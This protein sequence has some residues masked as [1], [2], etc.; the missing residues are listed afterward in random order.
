[1]HLKTITFPQKFA[2]RFNIAPTQ[3]VLAIPNDENMNADF[4]LWGLIPMWAKIPAL[5][6]A[7]QCTG[8]NAGRETILPRQS[9]IQALPGPCRRFL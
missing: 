3:P 9:E 6:T 1:M 7:H 2:P 8:R 5:E 4:F